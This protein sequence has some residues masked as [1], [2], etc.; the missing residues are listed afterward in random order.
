MRLTSVRLGTSADVEAAVEVYVSS[1]TA[2]RGGD[3]PHRDQRVAQVSARLRDADGWFLLAER[4]TQPVGMVAVVPYL[5]ADGDGPPVPGVSFMSLLFVI[6][7]LWGQGIGGRLVDAAVEEARRRGSREMRLWTDEENNER[8]HRLYLGHGFAH[9]GRTWMHDTGP[10]AEWI[11]NLHARVSTGISGSEHRRPGETAVLREIYLGQVWTARPATVVADSDE[12]VALYLPPG[13]RWQRPADPATGEWM[14]MHHGRWELREAEGIGAR[15]LH[16]MEPCTAHAIHLWWWPPNWRF[17]GWYVNLQEPLR[18]SDI[19]FDTLDNMLDV[20]ID[21]DRSWYWKDEDELAEAVR[22]GFVTQPWAND[23]RR[24]GERVIRR[25]ERDERP[26]S[27][28]WENWLP[29]PNWPMPSLP[30]VWKDAR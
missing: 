12:L 16:L 25:V 24:E 23:V 5:T 7:Q 14:R 17:G 29:D 20:V 28:G 3:W 21:P 19:G 9:S 4:G 30:A 10:V 27:D 6:P 2:R 15:S 26:F 18:R 22:I 8:A 13:T 11:G 1:N